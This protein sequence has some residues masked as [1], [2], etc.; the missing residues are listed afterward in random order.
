MLARYL[1]NSSM[2][3]PLA[4]IIGVSGMFSLWILGRP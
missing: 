2:G 4:L 3:D 1:D